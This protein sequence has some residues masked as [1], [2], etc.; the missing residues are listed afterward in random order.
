MYRQI[1][2]YLRA[3]L[4]FLRSGTLIFKERP[5]FANRRMDWKGIPFFTVHIV[6]FLKEREKSAKESNFHQIL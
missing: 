3:E 2:G 6:C 5:V 4:S 1:G